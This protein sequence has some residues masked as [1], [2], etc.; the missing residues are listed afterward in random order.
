MKHDLFAADSSKWIKA[1]F[2]VELM[3]HV[4]VGKGGVFAV[5]AK[6]DSVWYRTYEQGGKPV[7]K[8]LPDTDHGALWSKIQVSVFLHS[9][10]IKVFIRKL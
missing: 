1:D 7:G 5:K 2:A 4:S 3:K 9:K 6:D 10:C 8:V